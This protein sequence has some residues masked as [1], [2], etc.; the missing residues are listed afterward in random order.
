MNSE[1]V[2]NRLGI[3]G[4]CFQEI[5]Q[6]DLAFSSNTVGTIPQQSVDV[7]V[8]LAGRID[9]LS[10]VVFARFLIYFQNTCGVQHGR[11]IIESLPLCW[12]PRRRLE[13]VRQIGA[14]HVTN[15]GNHG[16]E[17]ISIFR[18]VKLRIYK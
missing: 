12:F 7:F 1:I 9:G 11:L 14:R 5:V 18:Q 2:R 17:Q 10:F 16:H 3:I 4:S 13:Q 6:L 15:P 8:E